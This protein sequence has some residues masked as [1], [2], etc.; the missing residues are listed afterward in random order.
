MLPD[1]WRIGEF[2]AE[3]TTRPGAWYTYATFR[4][5]EEATVYTLA[6]N[7]GTRVAIIERFYGKTRNPEQ[8]EELIR[9]RN[10]VRQ[11]GT[12]LDVLDNRWKPDC[13]TGKQSVERP[14]GS[15]A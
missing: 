15:P 12:I 2:N 5:T 13:Q 7:M 14:S 8:F 1:T 3:F 6:R 4:L 11:T 9:M 10:G